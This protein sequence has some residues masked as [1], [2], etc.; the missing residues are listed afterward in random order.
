MNNYFIPSEFN[1]GAHYNLSNLIYE[2]NYD[3]PKFVPILILEPR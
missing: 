1:V 2:P 3:P